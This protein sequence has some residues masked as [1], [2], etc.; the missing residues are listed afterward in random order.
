MTSWPGVREADLAPSGILRGFGGTTEISRA[1][2][3]TD[4]ERNQLDDHWLKQA[5]AYATRLC[6]GVPGP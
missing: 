1:R 4:Q 6:N 5:L 2:Y 3:L